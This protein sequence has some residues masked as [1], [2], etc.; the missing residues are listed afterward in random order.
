MVLLMDLFYG[1]TKGECSVTT[2][3]TTSKT[4]CFFNPHSTY[5]QIEPREQKPLFSNSHFVLK[6]QALFGD[7]EGLKVCLLI[8]LFEASGTVLPASPV[9]MHRSDFCTL[10]NPSQ[11]LVC[12]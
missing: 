8:Y 12:L 2:V 3:D 1:E 10:E 11:L 6:R 7:E 9:A 4:V 5:V